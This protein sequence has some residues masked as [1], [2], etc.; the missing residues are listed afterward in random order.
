M[1]APAKLLYK[2]VD[3]LNKKGIKHRTL[4]VIQG[5]MGGMVGSLKVPRK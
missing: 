3:Y 2:G 1:Q 5:D 4:P